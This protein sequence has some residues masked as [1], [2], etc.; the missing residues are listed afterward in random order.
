MVTSKDNI[1]HMI[2]GYNKI[3]KLT[4]ISSNKSSKSVIDKPLR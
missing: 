2:D 1:K 4:V 3:M